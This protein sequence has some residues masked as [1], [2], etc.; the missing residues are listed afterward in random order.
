VPVVG[1]GPPQPRGGLDARLEHQ[2]PGITGNAGKWSRRYSSPS[3]SSF[4]PASALPRLAAVDSVDQVEPHPRRS[5]FRATV[6]EGRVYRRGGRRTTE[7]AGAAC[8]YRARRP[9][10][11]QEADPA[12]GNGRRAAV[13]VARVAPAAPGGDRHLSRPAAGR[14]N[15]LS[16]E[17]PTL[18]DSVREIGSTTLWVGVAAPVGVRWVGRSGGC[19][20]GS[21]TASKPL[22]RRRAP[23]SRTSAGNSPRPWYTSGRPSGPALGRWGF[24]RWPGGS[25]DSAR[26]PGSRPSPARWPG[27]ARTSGPSSAKRSPR[28]APG[29][30]QRPRRSA[31]A[32]GRRRTGRGRGRLRVRGGDQAQAHAR[33]ARPAAIGP[34][35]VRGRL[36][37]GVHRRRAVRVDRQRRPARHPR[38]ASLRRGHRDQHRRADRPARVRSGPS[39]PRPRPP[40]P[41]ET[42]R[43]RRPRRRRPCGGRI[44]RGQVAVS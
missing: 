4:D 40:A 29:W 26:S 27:A 6:N 1:G 23:D 15:S 44:S 19:A 42:G 30:H 18:T 11:G 5:P 9:V 13:A 22:G 33:T 43:R 16:N 20:P 2:H 36:V 3:A 35:P 8:E 21:G 34:V 14:R 39:T 28:S 17:T 41:T 12:S 37:R 25:F 10:P 38:A 24:R 32:E 31:R 7:R